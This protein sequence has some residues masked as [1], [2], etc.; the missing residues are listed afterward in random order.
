MNKAMKKA[1]KKK[2]G[3]TRNEK[4]GALMA[5]A[6]YERK[7]RKKVDD[8]EIELYFTLFGLTM[9]ELYGWKKD[10]IGKVW[11]YADDLKTEYV[12]GNIT[13]EGLKQRLKE[14]ADI[15]CSFE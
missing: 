5:M 6:R 10:G 13:H 2:K 7:I 12:L 9:A 15:E 1:M 8:L 3:Y 14:I 4:A 11:K